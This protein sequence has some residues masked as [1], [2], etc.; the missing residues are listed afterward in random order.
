[1]SS[2]APNSRLALYEKLH[3]LFS[4]YHL[5]TG[6]LRE[7]ALASETEKLFE[8]VDLR[9]ETLARIERLQAAE[10]E[11]FGVPFDEEAD[12]AVKALRQAIRLSIAE[13]QAK[14]EG[15]I[16]RFTRLNEQIRAE[17]RQA[18]LTQRRVNGYTRQLTTPSRYIEERK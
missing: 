16:E 3:E 4:A 14:E 9:Q 1:M 10:P 12:P 11:A 18:N 8:L 2:Q 5:L 7:A 13:C 6:Q 15:L 17:A